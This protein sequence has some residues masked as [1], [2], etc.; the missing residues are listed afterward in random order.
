MAAPATHGVDLALLRCCHVLV[1]TRFMDDCG[2]DG[3]DGMS[4]L[5]V[6]V[7][8]QMC[9]Q[10]PRAGSV[11]GGN[12]DDDDGGEQGERREHIDPAL[13]D[14]IAHLEFRR[15]FRVMLVILVFSV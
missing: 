2:G 8:V 6:A 11:S 10:W 12:D 5:T 4:W 9:F 1:V 3:C 13:F 15:N 7:G 14:R